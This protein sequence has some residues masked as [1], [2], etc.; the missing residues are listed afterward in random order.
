MPLVL[1]MCALV[2]DGSGATGEPSAVWIS[3]CLTATTTTKD[4]ILY[5]LRTVQQRMGAALYV[6]PAIVSEKTLAQSRSPSKAVPGRLSLRGKVP[7]L[8]SALAGRHRSSAS[9]PS[10]DAAEGAAGGSSRTAPPP[11]AEIE[12]W[13]LCVQ[14][15]AG[16]YHYTGDTE[17]HSRTCLVKMPFVAEAALRSHEAFEAQR[18]QNTQQQQQPPT[19]TA[20]AK[21]SGSVFSAMDAVSNVQGL[22]F[23]FLHGVVLP[24]AQLR[25]CNPTKK[26]CKLYE[27]LD[28]PAVLR[29]EP[30]RVDPPPRHHPPMQRSTLPSSPLQSSPGPSPSTVEAVS[31]VEKEKSTAVV[32]DQPPPTVFPATLHRSASAQ[33]SASSSSSSSLLVPVPVNPAVTQETPQEVEA[34][35]TA[36]V[37]NGDMPHDGA[38]RPASALSMPATAVLPPQPVSDVVSAAAPGGVA[39]QVLLAEEEAVRDR[40]RQAHADYEEACRSAA[41][42]RTAPLQSVVGAHSELDG[43]SAASADPEL[44][45]LL[46]RRILLKEELAECAKAEKTCAQLVMRVEFYEAELAQGEARLKALSQAVE[47]TIAT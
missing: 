14:D 17:R 21:M 37:V 33:S 5:L 20:A 24:T 31:A 3:Y 2:T 38:T 44:R 39:D 41:A 32:G 4:A 8:T 29:A 15:A 35:L 30:L 7:T 9:Q 34:K 18:L 13:V 25:R 47:R 36:A 28:V 46:R 12:D 10:N 40:L 1:R 27:V 45:E 43:D 26:K 22:K 16:N 19:A 23:A 11:P 42:V 6:D